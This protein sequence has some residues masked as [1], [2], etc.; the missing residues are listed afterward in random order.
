MCLRWSPGEEK[1]HQ[2]GLEELYDLEHGTKC[3]VI[4]YDQSGVH[5]VLRAEGGT[6]D[7]LFHVNQLWLSESGGWVQFR[8]ILPSSS[9]AGRFPP[10]T[11]RIRCNARKVDAGDFQYQATAVWPDGKAPGEY[12][13]KA[14]YDDIQ[15]TASCVRNKLEVTAH[16]TSSGTREGVVQEYI[17][18]ETGV[19]RLLDGD[20][21]AALFSIENVWLC[22][23]DVW[24]PLVELDNQLLK[25]AAPVGTILY[26]IVKTLPA[27]RFSQLKYQA[28]IAWAGPE[29]DN[30]MPKEFEEKFNS[31]QKRIEMGRILVKQHETFKT[32]LR[33]DLFRS[34]PT[35]RDLVMVPVVL[36]LL[37][38]G[39]S[40]VIK[41]NENSDFGLITVKM[42]SPKDDSNL[43]F[44]VLF[45]L[46]DVIDELGA[47]AFKD[48]SVSMKSL[49]GVEVD[50]TARSIVQADEAN[51]L[52]RLTQKLHTDY[53]DAKIPILQAVKVFRKVRD[54]ITT[55]EGPLPTFIRKEPKSLNKRHS[56]T[57]FYLNIS[58]RN[59]LD[60]KVLEFIDS[61]STLEKN[62]IPNF[63]NPWFLKPDYKEF[64]KKE[65]PRRIPKSLEALDVHQNCKHFYGEFLAMEATPP[66]NPPEDLT[67]HSARVCLIHVDRRKPRKGLLEVTLDRNT[68]TYVFFILR[69]VQGDQKSFGDLTNLLTVNMRTK[70]SVNAKLIDRKSK[71]PYV[72]TAVWKTKEDPPRKSGDLKMLKEEWKKGTEA[73]IKEWTVKTIEMLRRKED[74]ENT[75]K[76]AEEALSRAAAKEAPKEKESTAKPMEVDE[77]DVREEDK[78]WR[79]EPSFRDKIGTVHKVINK[80]YALGTSYHSVGFE[81]RRFFVLFDTT[82]VWING[83][84]LQKRGKNMTD[85]LAVNDHIK[86]HSVYVDVENEWNLCYLATAVIVNKT[87]SGARDD[88]MPA[89]ALLKSSA[90]EVNPEKVANFK[91]VAEKLTKKQVPVDPNEEERKEIMKKRRADAEKFRLERQRRQEDEKRRREIE[92]ERQEKLLQRNA[93]EMEKKAILRRQELMRI[94]PAVMIELQGMEIIRGTERL[95]TCKLCGIQ[96]MSLPDAES[97]I[98]DKDHKAL[99][100]D[101]DRLEGNTGN[102]MTREEV[103]EKLFLNEYKEIKPFILN[104]KRLYSCEKCKALK[105]PLDKIKKHVTSILHKNNHKQKTNSAQLDQECKEMKK[106]GRVSVSYLCTPCGF[107]SDSVIATKN[108]IEEEA[109]KK[110]TVNYCHACKQF[111]NNRAKFQEHRFSIAH[112]RKM[113]ELEKPQEEKQ[114]KEKAEQKKKRREEEEAEVEVETEVQKEPE[115]PL[116]CK[117]CNF[118]A[119]DEDEVKVHN[120]TES[121]R[122]KY[123]LKFGKMP[124]EEEED[125]ETVGEKPFT[126]LEHM[127]L[128][129]KAK[130]IDDKVKK[131]RSL[132]MDE[133]LKKEKTSI[134]DTLF[135]HSV[136]EKMN[137]NSM[138]KCSSCDVKLQGHQ[139]QK[140]LYAQLFVHFTSDKHIQRLRVHVKDEEAAANNPQEVTDVEEEA[141]S[142]EPVTE[143]PEER[144]VLPDPIVVSQ[145]QFYTDEEGLEMFSILRA[146]EEEDEDKPVKEME[147]IKSRT[148]NLLYCVPCK[149][150]LMSG[151]YMARHFDSAAHKEKAPVASWRTVLDLSCVLEFGNLYKCLYCNTAFMK[152]WQLE[153]HF[154]TRDHKEQRDNCINEDFTF[155]QNIPVDPPRCDTCDVYFSSEGEMRC[156]MITKLHHIRTYQANCLPIS[157]F[158]DNNNLEERLEALPPPPLPVLSPRLGNQHGRIAGI[159]ETGRFVII[160]FSVDDCPLHAL[161]DKSRVA[162]KER[163]TFPVVGYPVTFNC[164]RIEPEVAG[165]S[166]FVQYWASSVVMGDGANTDSLG[167]EMT[168]SQLRREEGGVID[169]GL[170]DCKAEMK[171]QVESKECGELTVLFDELP[172][173]VVFEAAVVTVKTESSALLRIHKTGQLALLILEKTPLTLLEHKVVETSEDLQLDSEVFINAV[174]M[175]VT[176]RAPYLVTSLWTSE[177]KPSLKREKLRQ[178]CIDMYHAL[179]LALQ[180][181]P[182]H[183]DLVIPSLY[184]MQ[185]LTDVDMSGVIDI[186]KMMMTGDIGHH[187]NIADDSIADDDDDISDPGE[188]SKSF[189]IRIASFAN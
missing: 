132:A 149:T 136:F 150:G 11:T 170:E 100:A 45:H 57:G 145:Y 37:P 113:E 79:W 54:K 118:E 183:A 151:K 179:V 140:K 125:G 176:R 112:K 50:L 98:E 103:E 152:L 17:S 102:A 99:K 105:L 6:Q 147:S 88:Q 182:S 20:H 41:D 38:P 60:V 189:G 75:M 167:T 154:T 25:E 32:V 95:Y 58:L 5:G 4:R 40:A 22:E 51:D 47:Q 181:E 82:D 177:S 8:E 135:S 59:S 164:A 172:E 19:I 69:N 30:S 90:A 14:W 83:E 110:K 123:Y 141:P 104:G 65:M 101:Q 81:E 31:R 107:T 29:E 85:A 175:D 46:E 137:D 169:I 109:H 71:I 121:H 64:I 126:S 178:G 76:K 144:I 185:D 48:K 142:E 80:N 159:F 171:A 153:L 77:K 134:I 1:Q 18:F 43:S 34:F 92:Q 168:F 127:T 114:N 21:G 87:Q 173:Y 12:R 3:V 72:A 66:K 44:F 35:K 166:Q 63:F 91:K 42:P 55:G 115:D 111:S 49:S 155:D 94:K 78:E 27:N 26:V 24:K 143:S 130:D 146:Q 23:K 158:T 96:S 84:V 106:K 56:A 10:L 174:L 129:H 165:L 180:P 70:I 15:R 108:H 186:N 157:H 9:L 2:A 138:Y 62:A 128:V 119:E 160:Q 39:G 187:D 86:F 61:C 73:I 68:K 28:I 184:A 162:N 161:F 67:E 124:S 148:S 139:Q 133:D 131:S 74:I 53:P 33:F 188:K 13:T 16:L 156:H 122:R 116:K 7:I 117:V 120:R 52:V 89:Q 97:H 36:N 163:S 93:E